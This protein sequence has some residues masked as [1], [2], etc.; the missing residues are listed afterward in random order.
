MRVIAGSAKGCSLLSPKGIDVRP[1]ADRVKESLFNILSPYLYGAYFLDLYS[2]TGAIGIEALSRG[3]KRT[4]FV[5]S[6]RKNAE[7]IKRN[8][9]HTRLLEKAEIMLCDAHA[10][11]NKQTEGFDLIFMDPPYNKE[12]VAPTLKLIHK[13]GALKPSGLCIAE[14]SAYEKLP[15]LPYF[16]VFKEKSYNYVNIAIYRLLGGLNL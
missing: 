5:E 7:Y 15:V 12:L 16:E 13:N 8:L 14:Y 3:A 1:T 4:V 2:G 10:F 6:S 9:E 11:L